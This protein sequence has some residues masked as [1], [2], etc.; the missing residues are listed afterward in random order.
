MALPDGIG[1]AKW[2]MAVSDEELEAS[3]DFYRSL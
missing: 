3:F 1:K 2:D